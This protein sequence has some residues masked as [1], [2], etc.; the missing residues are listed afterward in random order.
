MKGKILFIWYKRSK[1]I[2]EGGGQGSKRNYY[3]CEQVAGADNVDSLYI[4]DEFRKKRVWDYAQ[5]LWGFPLGYYYGITPARLREIVKTA[6]GY[7]YV[8]IDRSIFG[9]VA[10]EL[11]EAGYKG[12]IIVFFHN[13]E[14]VYFDEA[15][16]PKRLPFRS[17][18]LRC[19][20]RNERQAMK[21][22]DI[23]LALNDRDNAVLKQLYGREADM[24]FPVSMIDKYVPQD[25][26]VMTSQRLRC[27]TIGAYFAPNNDGILWF[28]KNVLPK[29]DIEYK[30][31]GKG[32]GKLKAEHPDL[33]GNI[34]VV[35]DAPDL[36]PYFREA[37]C[38][39]LPIFSGSGMKVKTCESLMQGKNIL[40]ST[41]AFEGY[42]VDFDKV[43]GL[44]NTPDEFIAAIR[45]LEANPVPRVNSYS[46][47]IFCEKY[48]AETMVENLRK[49]ME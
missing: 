35:N 15:K 14:R 36:A 1:G 33:L 17:V 24:L 10:K 28:V 39:I 7:E 26:T 8:W 18:V 19:V 44:C 29:V 31:V 12:K 27:L 37:D 47:Q 48:S 4:H 6:R 23:V 2:L 42:D 20:T 16:L 49:V 30:V 41:E 34:E 38:M 40:A 11:K 5:A 45:R 3:L 43:G 32:M 25:E 21:Y 9:V 22:S 46:R 13:V